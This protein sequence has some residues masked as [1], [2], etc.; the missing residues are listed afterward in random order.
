MDEVEVVV[1]HSERATLRAGDVYLK[2]DGDA[3]NADLEARAMAL[4]PVPTPTI[5]WR[6]PPVLAITAVPGQALGA[7]GE[8]STSSPAA[9]AAA[10]AAIRTLHDAPLPP[11]EGPALEDVRADLDR[12]CS[13][14]LANAVLPEDIIRRNREIAETALRPCTPAFIH[15]DLQSAHVFIH[16]DE[17][18]GVINWSGAS[19]GDAMARWLI[20]HGFDPDA[21]GCEFDVLR[22][23]MAAP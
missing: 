6:E 22:A 19:P 5:L 3:A 17:V 20:D 13:W 7:L 1:A 9:W 8:P 18:V 10:G 23:Q 16:D 4:A 11:W 21:P 12:E 15:G 2:I 14:L